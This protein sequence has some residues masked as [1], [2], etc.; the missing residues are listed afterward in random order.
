MA[1]HTGCVLFPSS[2]VVLLLHGEIGREEKSLRLL[3]SLSSPFVCFAV[4]SQLFDKCVIFK[5]LRTS[6]RVER[7]MVWQ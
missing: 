5:D 2:N 7:L 1:L 6:F 3:Q 4:S